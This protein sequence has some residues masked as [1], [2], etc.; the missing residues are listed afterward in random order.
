[1]P[2]VITPNGDGKNDLFTPLKCPS[3][4]QSL[5]FK[6]FNRWGAKVYDS[7]DVNI[8]WNGKNNSGN[9]L[10]AGQYYYEV[11]VNFESVQR[12]GKPATFKGWVQILR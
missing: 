4:V 9:D 2:N 3:F 10:A 11:I 1:L 5:D 7:K 12:E 6:V 8:N